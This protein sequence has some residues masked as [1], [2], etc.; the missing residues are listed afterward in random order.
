MAE[1]NGTTVVEL[2]EHWIIQIE[3][4]ILSLTLYDLM[5]ILEK[6]QANASLI[7]DFLWTDG[8]LEIMSDSGSGGQWTHLL[9]Q[10]LWKLSRV[11]G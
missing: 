2:L 6:Q 9:K 8:E 7:Q 1:E 11:Y 3:T 10:G 5:W 4:W